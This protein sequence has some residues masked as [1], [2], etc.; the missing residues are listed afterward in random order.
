M[1]CISLVELNP[2]PP[3]VT[4]LLHTLHWLVVFLSLGLK[5]RCSKNMLGE[6]LCLQ[7]VS[8]L[9]LT[10]PT[11]TQR[12]FVNKAVL[13]LLLVEIRPSASF[14][15]TI[16][17]P[18]S[19]HLDLRHFTLNTSY[20]LHFLVINTCQMFSFLSHTNTHTQLYIALR[21]TVLSVY[22]F[23]LFLEA[24]IE[25]LYTKLSTKTKYQ[26][27]YRCRFW[28]WNLCSALHTNAQHTHLISAFS[29]HKQCPSLSHSLH[30]P[31]V[32]RSWRGELSG[33]SSFLSSPPLSPLSP[34]VT[35]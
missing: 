16:E 26:R 3:D 4:L 34:S 5:S 27:L 18:L 29:Q 6:I 13:I 19:R 31:S 17:P 14:T 11:L 9:Q 1:F 2:E 35:P 21:K 12:S 22:L 15:Q 32:I 28:V 20:S 8:D 23:F 24:N 10:G 25:L 30:A 33:H 7:G